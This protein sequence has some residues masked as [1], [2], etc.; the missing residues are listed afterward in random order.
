MLS[1]QAIV[2][3]TKGFC[4]GTKM[5]GDVGTLLTGLNPFLRS[6]CAFYL[7]HQHAFQADQ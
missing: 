5:A 1:R 4:G 6:L 3:R 7:Q 2:T